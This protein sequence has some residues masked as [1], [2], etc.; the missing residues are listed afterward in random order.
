MNMNMNAVLVDEDEL[1]G[2]DSN[3]LAEEFRGINLRRR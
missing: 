2:I 3:L 1:N